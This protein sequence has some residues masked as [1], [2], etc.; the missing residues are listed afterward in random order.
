MACIASLELH[1]NYYQEKKEQRGK[2]NVDVIRYV[3]GSTGVSENKCGEDWAIAK[4]LEGFVGKN[5][6]WDREALEPEMIE[7]LGSNIGWNGLR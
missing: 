6:A 7:N 1:N 2:Y 3:V 5:R 4:V